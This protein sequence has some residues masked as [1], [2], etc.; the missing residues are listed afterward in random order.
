MPDI[1]K[2]TAIAKS[3]IN[4]KDL[5]IDDSVD[6]FSNKYL[7]FRMAT[8]KAGPKEKKKKPTFIFSSSISNKEIFSLNNRNMKLTSFNLA[9]QINSGKNLFKGFKQQ[10]LDDYY[11][12]NK[13]PAKSEG[14]SEIP[15]IKSEL[16]NSDHNDIIKSAR[17]EFQ[18]KIKSNVDLDDSNKSFEGINFDYTGSEESI[19][20]VKI[21]HEVNLWPK[22]LNDLPISLKYRIKNTIDYNNAINGYSNY[23]IENIRIEIINDKKNDENE[24]TITINNDKNNRTDGS[25]NSLIFFNSNINSIHENKEYN[26]NET[27]NNGKDYNNLKTEP[28][29]KINFNSV[30]KIH[31]KIKKKKKRE[32]SE[33]LQKSTKSNSKL[34]LSP[35]HSSY[36]FSHI[37]NGT[38]NY[39][40]SFQREITN[41][42][43][44][45]S[46]EHDTLKNTVTFTQN[47]SENYIS[48]FVI[49]SSYQNLN[50]ASKGKYI[51]DKKLQEK[52]IKYIKLKTIKTRLTQKLDLQTLMKANSEVTN[53]KK[54]EN[55]IK[56]VKTRMTNL[57]KK[58]RLEKEAKTF[59]IKKKLSLSPR[60]KTKKRLTKL[61]QTVSK[62]NNNNNNEF[63]NSNSLLNSLS[64]NPNE[65]LAKLNCSNNDFI[66]NKLESHE[67]NNNFF[68]QIIK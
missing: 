20:T 51:K 56:N 29:N 3:L 39:S 5:E 62:V 36:F 41:S 16:E 35:M 64:Y 6:D 2:K 49:K 14:L 57:I 30:I 8:K 25:K 48:S 21:D 37:M 17:K 18:T 7:F 43:M 38:H 47:L 58:K 52:T 59:C 45:K 23:K 44:E 65:T 24:N 31:N 61:N 19:K 63:N 33:Q 40:R 54:L 46:H 10:Y 13:F 42:I 67:T 34:S 60:I 15:H 11:S 1:L 53:Y 27:I 26:N 4:D 22:T 28:E 68:N 9:P 66:E 55:T 32:K 50:Q 12:L